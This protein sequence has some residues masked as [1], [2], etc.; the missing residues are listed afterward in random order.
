MNEAPNPGEVQ[1]M[2]PGIRR[3]LAPNASTMTYW[4]TNSYLIGERSLAVIDPGP[5]DPAH[6]AALLNGVGGAR[7]EAILVTH[8]HLDH[9]ALARLLSNETGAPVL[10]FG[11]YDAGRSATM[12]RLARSGRVRGGEGVDTGFRPDD[13]LRDGDMIALAD[14]KLEVL[15]TP[16]HFPGHLSFSFGDSLFSGDHVMG[17][18]TT[19]ISPPEGDVRAFFDTCGRLLERDEKRYF[20]GHGPPV[21]MPETRVA[22][23]VAHR[24][25]REMQILNELANGPKSADA[26]A[27]RIYSEVPTE[28]LP[29]ASRNVFAHLIDLADRNE[30]VADPEVGWNAQFSV[31]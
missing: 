31:R 28:L 7:V 2:A 15:H 16:G 30:V 9:S 25:E 24:T 26:L 20:P 21:E 3:I 19:L 14:A 22:D 11:P 17:W 13:T 27:Q 6:L 23:L 18:S 29:A 5:A 1:E 10:A 4:G 12:E 8:A